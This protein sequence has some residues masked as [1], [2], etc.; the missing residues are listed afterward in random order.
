VQA[1]VTRTLVERQL[2][3]VRELTQTN[4][5]EVEADLD[6]LTVEVRMQSPVDG[7]EYVVRFDCTGYDEKPPHVEMVHPETGEVGHYEAYFDDRGKNPFLIA[8]DDGP[9]HPV[10]CHQ[11][12]RR[13]YDDDTD[14]HNNW[15][16]GD[17]QSDA[18]NLTTLG[19]IAADI[20]HRISDP[21][22]YQG[23]YDGQR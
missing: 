17:W 9:G 16:V 20:Y 11:Y 14:L 23:R 15:T 1:D 19:D 2:A 22:R 5:W 6:A 7:E 10:L 8:F 4:G 21:E 18:G 13:V 12:N 3:D